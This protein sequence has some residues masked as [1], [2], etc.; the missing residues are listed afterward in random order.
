[1]REIRGERTHQIVEPIGSGFEALFVGVARS[2]QQRNHRYAGQSSK[3]P[4]ELLG[5]IKSPFGE[6]L[7]AQ[8][9]VSDPLGC[10]GPRLALAV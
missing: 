9:D 10:I 7:S 5:L 3:L 4:G 1:M 6:P 8:G 2:G